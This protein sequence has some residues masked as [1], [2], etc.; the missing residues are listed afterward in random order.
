M[1]PSYVKPFLWSYDTKAI[2]P[3]KDK[4]TIILNV[5]NLGTK[6]ATDWLFRNYSFKEIK[7]AIRSTYEGEWGEK[8]LNLWRMVFKV[9]P[10]KKRNVVLR[11]LG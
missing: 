4:R 1:I 8:S 3:E 6:E 5:L 7:E 11:N 2:S 9:N 10:K